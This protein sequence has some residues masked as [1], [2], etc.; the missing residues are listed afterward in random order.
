MRKLVINPWAVLVCVILSM[1]VG[2]LWYGTFSEQWMA[3]NELDLEFIQ[4]N[5]SATPY[6]I[7][8]IG[9]ILSSLCMAWLFTKIPVESAGRGLL[10]GLVFGLAFNF[11]N[12]YT[13]NSFAF[14]SFDHTW[15]D[16]GESVVNFALLGLILGGWRKYR[17]S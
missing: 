17:E 3:A 16:G 4:A 12:T 14:R 9:S 1:V 13:H 8:T 10:L 2:A 6:I 7:A 15:I 5:E 11:F